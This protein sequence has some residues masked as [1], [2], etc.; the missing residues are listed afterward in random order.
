MVKVTIDID[1]PEGYRVIGFGYPNKGDWFLCG[2]SEVFQATHTWT[3]R[4]V[5]L[6]EK[7]PEPFIF[8]DCVAKGTWFARDKSGE[9]WFHDHEPYMRDEMWASRGTQVRVIS[10]IFNIVVPEGPWEESKCRN[11]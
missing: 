2:S 1:V 9:A 8:P 5:I 4:K 3:I 10:R 11:V 7:L 6:L